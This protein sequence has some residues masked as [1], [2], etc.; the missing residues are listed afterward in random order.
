MIALRLDAPLLNSV[1]AQML[2]EY[3]L[4]YRDG[5]LLGRVPLS[6]ATITFSVVPSCTASH[7]LLSLPF[8]EIQADKAPAF[9]MPK[10]VGLFW[11]KLSQEIENRLL[12]Q[13]AGA[14]LPAHTVTTQRVD[15]PEGDVGILLVSLEAANSWLAQRHP[16]LRSSILEIV[17]ASDSVEVRGTLVE[18]A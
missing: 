6:L 12:P 7:L 2:P 4:K 5:C 18:K 9:L 10:L 1:A 8:Q 16:R 11:G 15:S 3:D 14:G 17:F 13:L